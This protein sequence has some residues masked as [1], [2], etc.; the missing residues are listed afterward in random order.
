MREV[1]DRSCEAISNSNNLPSTSSVFSHD[2]LGSMDDET[3][4]LKMTVPQLETKMYMEDE[5][6]SISC[7]HEVEQVGHMKA[8]TT[9]TPTSHEKD[10]KGMGVDVTM[11]PLV[12]MIN[13]DSMHVMYETIDVTYDSFLFP[14]DDTFPYTCHLLSDSISLPLSI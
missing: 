1:V 7:L 6:A 13:D 5:G 12:D 2:V 4:L 3:P 9:T 10:N 8:P 14:C 11:I